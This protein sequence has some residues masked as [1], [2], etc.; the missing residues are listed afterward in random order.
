VRAGEAIWHHESSLQR[1]VLGDPTIG[2]WT[3]N[4]VACYAAQDF[5]EYVTEDDPR[6]VWVLRCERPAC[7]RWFIPTRRRRTTRH[8]CSQECRRWYR[9]SSMVNRQWSIVNS[10][11][12]SK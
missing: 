11:P 2:V 5:V 3:Y 7:G 9:Q 12:G 10:Q 8:F 6:A 4:D 1:G